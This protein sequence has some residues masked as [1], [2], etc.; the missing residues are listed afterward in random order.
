MAKTSTPSYSTELDAL[1][2][3]FKGTTYMPNEAAVVLRDIADSG[4]GWY[5]S[6]SPQELGKVL[7]GLCEGASTWSG[8]SPMFKVMRGWQKAARKR[9]QRHLRFAEIWERHRDDKEA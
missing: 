4:P 9:R 8:G 7:E 5:R 1:S 3:E 2:A 6:I